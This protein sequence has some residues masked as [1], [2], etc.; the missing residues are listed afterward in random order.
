MM[1]RGVLPLTIVSLIPQIGRVSKWADEN[2]DMVF[3]VCIL[4]L[5]DDVDFREKWGLSQI[6]I[7][8][9]VESQPISCDLR[10]D[11]EALDPTVFTRG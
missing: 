11:I 4:H 9:Q 2:G 7:I 10:F 3:P 8:R 1:V 6:G 5:K